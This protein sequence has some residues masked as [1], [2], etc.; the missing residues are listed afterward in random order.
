M[1]T[2]IAGDF[3]AT[4]PGVLAAHA[5][6]PFAGTATGTIFGGAKQV[7][8]G[9]VTMVA[10]AFEEYIAVT[11]AVAGG[12]VFKATDCALEVVTVAALEAATVAA[13]T[14]GMVTAAAFGGV[15]T[16]AFGVVT[17]AVALGEVT[18]V[19]LDAATDAA[20]GAVTTAAAF[21][22][23]TA[24]VALETGTSL[25]VVPGV[26]GGLFAGRTDTFTGTAFLLVKVGL[27]I[28]F[29][30]KRLRGVVCSLA[31]NSLATL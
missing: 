17:T 28:W 15:T 31:S 9:A 24:G 3:T 8:L 30:K 12:D 4:M 6:T 2:G 5:T 29:R 22:A 20:F 19:A 7:V 18:V 11:L 21:E 10:A 13:A 26:S 25:A 16:V 27:L 23:A 14:L 1:E